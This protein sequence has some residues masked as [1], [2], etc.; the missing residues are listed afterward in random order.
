MA[1]RYKITPKKEALKLIKPEHIVE[2][3][4]SSKPGYHIRDGKLIV[5]RISRST[6]NLIKGEEIDC[7][8]INI[9]KVQNS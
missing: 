7:P 5:C 4:Y 1:W 3:D 9:G 8:F 2:V 6:F